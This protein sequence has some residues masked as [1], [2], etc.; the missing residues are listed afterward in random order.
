[1]HPSMLQLTTMFKEQ[2]RVELLR[3]N[4]GLLTFSRV[5]LSTSSRRKAV[6]LQVVYRRRARKYRSSDVA[7]YPVHT[8]T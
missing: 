4:V 8:V 6:T 3:D 7:M 5:Q 1:M 2:Q